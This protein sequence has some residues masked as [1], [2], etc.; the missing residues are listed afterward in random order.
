[1]GLHGYD[2]T[3]YTIFVIHT[4]FINDEMCGTELPICEVKIGISV[5]CKG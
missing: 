5:V 4:L 2:I 1:M 3:H